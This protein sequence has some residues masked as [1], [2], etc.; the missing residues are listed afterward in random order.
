MGAKARVRRSSSCTC[1]WGVRLQG[2]CH[3]WSSFA[4]TQ[5]WMCDMF[6]DL[7][8]GSEA[9]FQVECST[10]AEA[11][12]QKQKLWVQGPRCGLPACLDRFHLSVVSLTG[13]TKNSLDFTTEFSSRSR[14][15]ILVELWGKE[16]KMLTSSSKGISKKK[17]VCICTLQN[18]QRASPHSG[19]LLPYLCNSHRHFLQVVSTHTG[20][21]VTLRQLRI[22][23]EGYSILV[24]PLPFLPPQGKNPPSQG[25]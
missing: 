8:S 11:C 21:P 2:M 12:H 9:Q 23:T 24:P 4:A 20:L 16:N 5:G 25:M 6:W 18:H 14:M 3:P 17:L 15:Q 19:H 10:R 1:L 22:W 13:A 7:V